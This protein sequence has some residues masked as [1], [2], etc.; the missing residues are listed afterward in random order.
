[1]A[2]I[3]YEPSL[4]KTGVNVTPAF[5]VFHTPPEATATKDLLRFD[6]TTAR[7]AT[8]SEVNA[9]P[10]NRIRNS[11]KVG[12]DIGSCGRGRAGS[13]ASR[14]IRG[15]TTRINPL[16]F[17]TDF[18]QSSGICEHLSIHLRGRDIG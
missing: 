9:G 7:P 17:T 3:E 15:T 18:M 10:I 1:M 12:V 8:R 2:P 13:C 11:L 16:S 6:G 4:S 5:V 14:T